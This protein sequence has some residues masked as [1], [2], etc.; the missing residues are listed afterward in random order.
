MNTSSKKSRKFLK[1]SITLKKA[2]TTHPL[3]PNSKK[4]YK[5]NQSSKKYFK[6]K[7][8]TSRA[9]FKLPLISSTIKRLWTSN[10]KEKSQK[11]T[12]NSANSRI[13]LKFSNNNLNLIPS[14]PNIQKKTFKV[15]SKPL[16]PNSSALKKDKVNFLTKPWSYKVIWIKKIPNFITLPFKTPN[17][18]LTIITFFKCFKTMN[19]E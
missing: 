8:L 15:N 13:R 5:N 10:T 9:S 7:H 2:K 11:W 4:K 12:I 19:L 6:S 1:P 14:I 18:K 3:S 17:F 16:R